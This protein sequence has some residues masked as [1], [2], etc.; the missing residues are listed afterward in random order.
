M[1]LCV[2]LKTGEGLILASDSRGT[3]GDPRGLTAI[4][5]DQEKLAQIGARC[6]L[7][8]SGASE[9]ARTLVDGI[10]DKYSVAGLPD[11]IEEVVGIL[12]TELLDSYVKWFGRRTWL[13][14]QPVL[15]QRPVIMAVVAG[16]KNGEGQIW[17]LNSQVDFVPMKHHD[18]A[19]IGVVN[20]AV[21]LKHRFYDKAMGLDSGKSLVSF[22]IAETASQ[23]PKVGGPISMAT[24]TATEGYQLVDKDEVERIVT[25]NEQQSA[26]LREWFLHPGAAA[27]IASTAESSGGS[28]GGI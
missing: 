9:I 28:A 13:P 16:Y 8:V 20:Y 25:A 15:D 7:A 19:M 4:S 2:A 5:D 26:G 22:L 23:D 24:I 27:A 1:T 17:S 10:K 3:I 6:G 21:Y 12:H 14:P 11:N 18:S